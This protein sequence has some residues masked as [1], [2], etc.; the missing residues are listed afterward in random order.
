MKEQ[1]IAV[2]DYQLLQPRL[3]YLGHVVSAEGIAPDVEKTKKVNQWPT[4]QSPKEVQQ[5]LGLANYYRR[6]I[7]DFASLAKPLYR[8]TEKGA[9]F[10]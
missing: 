4:L 10:I 8:L 1:T 6:F 9:R 5:F 2:T 7:Q 3:T